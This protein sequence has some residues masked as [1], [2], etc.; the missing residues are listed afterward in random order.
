M[1]GYLDIGIAEDSS[2]S[3]V[4]LGG[5]GLLLES[6]E[7][8]ADVDRFVGSLIGKIL[9]LIDGSIHVI[10]TRLLSLNVT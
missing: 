5:F 1:N 3:E 6:L 4:V 7:D 2:D 8:A 9:L 10:V